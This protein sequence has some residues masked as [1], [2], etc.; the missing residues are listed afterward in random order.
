[1][2][3]EVLKFT[4]VLSV[5]ALCAAGG[6]AAQG[7]A[8]GRPPAQGAA[9]G[10]GIFEPMPSD[11]SQASTGS[12][13]LRF[14]LIPGRPANTLLVFGYV[15]AGDRLRFG[16]A[17]TAA[18]PV[19]EVQFLS[20]G[21]SLGD[22]I[23]IGRLIRRNSLATRVVS[24]GICAS[25]CNFMFMGGVVRTVEPGG[26]FMVHMFRNAAGRRLIEDIRRPPG[27][28][29]EFN[30]RYPYLQLRQYMVEQDVAKHNEEHPANPIT[31]MQDYLRSPPIQQMVVERRTQDIQKE[32]AQVAAHIAVFLL[33][34]R[35]SIQF[36]TRFA[37]VSA[38]D[39]HTMTPA[40]LR[41]LNVVTN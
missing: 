6:A 5:A 2:V 10:G 13:N 28:L 18:R 9:P 22:G 20:G 31:T 32:S 4:L 38:S 16:A 25:A 19:G 12:P 14:V 17:L 27:S 34:M 36:L 1:M 35:L 11:M 8:Q 7:Q 15:G 23:E 29:D 26:L 33:E 37:E 30:H 40:E 21:G 41:E 39:M 24:G 3:R